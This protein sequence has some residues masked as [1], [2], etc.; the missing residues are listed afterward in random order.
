MIFTD[1]YL[2]FFYDGQQWLLFQ[3]YREY[4]LIA[5]N[6]LDEIIDV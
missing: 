3:K 6:S 1:E 5:F 4:R 2:E